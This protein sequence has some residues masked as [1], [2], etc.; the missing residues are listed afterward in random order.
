[1]PIG[2]G[3]RLA[4]KFLKQVPFAGDIVVGF[5]ELYNPAEADAYQRVLNALLVGGG[6]ALASA[7]SGGLD[8]IPGIAGVVAD[9]PLEN[10]NPETILRR[11]SYMMGQGKDPGRT[12]GEQLRNIQE[13]SKGK[14]RQPSPDYSEVPLRF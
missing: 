4:G 14:T 13:W 1:M 5:S 7:A 9:T 3:F 12:T 2:K 6:G 8:F 11:L 10:V